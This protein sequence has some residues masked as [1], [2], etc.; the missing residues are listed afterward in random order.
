M[1]DWFND[2]SI[3]GKP[4]ADDAEFQKV[5]G[6]KTRFQVPESLLKYRVLNVLCNTVL[7]CSLNIATC[8]SLQYFIS[9]NM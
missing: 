2:V 9:I 1:A 4:S 6:Q 5:K 8:A 7:P 3:L